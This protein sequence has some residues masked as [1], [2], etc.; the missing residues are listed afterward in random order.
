[1]DSKVEG[2]YVHFF[3]FV[4]FTSHKNGHLVPRIHLGISLTNIETRY[5]S[6][7]HMDIDISACK[8][9]L[10]Y[11][12]QDIFN[13]YEISLSYPVCYTRYPLSVPTFSHA[14]GHIFI[15]RWIRGSRFWARLGYASIG[16]RAS[17]WVMY[18]SR[19]LR[20][21]CILPSHLGT[22]LLKLRV[23]TWTTVIWELW[24][25]FC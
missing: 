17:R 21:V 7:N 14:R 12:Q 22:D 5:I 19:A 9:I 20:S 18:F 4:R 6:C 15:A 10:V 11:S 13:I 2:E 25:L 23:K 8:R 3:I 1:M 24:V 16:F